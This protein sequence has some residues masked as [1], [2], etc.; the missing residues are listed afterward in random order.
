MHLHD[1]T[2]FFVFLIRPDVRTSSLIPTSRIEL[3]AETK[4]TH[5]A[6]V[7]LS[8]HPSVAA[9]NVLWVYWVYK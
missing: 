2:G 7:Q 9:W 3:H 4:K 6:E 1:Q 5:M 8:L